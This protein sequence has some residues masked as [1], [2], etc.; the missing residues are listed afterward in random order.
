MKP[1]M[2][3]GSTLRSSIKAHRAYRVFRESLA[4]LERRGQLGR[5]AFLAYRVLL[6]HRELSALLELQANKAP[7]P[8][9]RAHGWLA[10]LMI[11]GMQFFI[12]VPAMSH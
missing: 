7:R 11:W 2:L 6:V 5:K 12:T 8:P 4:L 3:L 1:A 10:V 9:S